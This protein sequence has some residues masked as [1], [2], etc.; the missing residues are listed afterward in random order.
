MAAVAAAERRDWTPARAEVIVGGAMDIFT[1]EQW[2]G[3]TRR[4]RGKERGVGGMNR[5]IDGVRWRIRDGARWRQ[6][7]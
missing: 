4:E 7:G 1:D 3:D 6:C 2:K 5:S